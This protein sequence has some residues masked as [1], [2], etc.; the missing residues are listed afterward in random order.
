MNCAP[1]VGQPESESYFKKKLQKKKEKESESG[2]IQR[3]YPCRH[4]ENLEETTLSLKI[5]E[6]ETPREDPVLGQFPWG[7]P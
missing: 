1:Y 3:I 2:V 7:H 6:L 4:W 5:R